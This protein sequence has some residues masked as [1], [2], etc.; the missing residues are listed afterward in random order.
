MWIAGT[1][2]K[3]CD[4]MKKQFHNDSSPVEKP[5]NIES[6][7]ST[8]MTDF[9]KISVSHRPSRQNLSVR[10]FSVATR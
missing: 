6:S 8:N 3:A 4:A 5:W 7:F 10:R 2:K 9:A 1:L